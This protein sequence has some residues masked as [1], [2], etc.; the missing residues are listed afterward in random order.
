MRGLVD[1]QPTFAIG[2]QFAGYDVKHAWGE[3][4]H[5]GEHAKVILPEALKWLWRDYP[6]PV[7]AGAPAKAIIQPRFLEKV[8]GW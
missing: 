6:S 8:G 1:R 3:G 7:V 2:S 5:N 4:G